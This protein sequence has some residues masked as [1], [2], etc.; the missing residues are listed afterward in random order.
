MYSENVYNS[1]YI[2]IL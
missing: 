2:F 1:Y